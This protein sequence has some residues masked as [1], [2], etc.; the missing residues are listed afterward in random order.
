MK[1]RAIGGSLISDDESESA[2]INC[3]VQWQMMSCDD[4]EPAKT[5]CGSLHSSVSAHQ[6]HEQQTITNE[7]RENQR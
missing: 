5:P 4:V 6:Q 2:R 1:P 7:T 3:A